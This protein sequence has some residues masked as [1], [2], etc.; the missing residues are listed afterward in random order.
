MT[1]DNEITAA[2]AYAEALA[3]EFLA[4]ID[5]YLDGLD[6]G[7]SVADAEDARAF[8]ALM[9][10]K[11]PPDWYTVPGGQPEFESPW[12]IAL[13]E[14]YIDEPKG[15]WRGVSKALEEMRATS[16]R[17]MRPQRLGVM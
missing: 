11:Y 14:G 2:V 8:V 17:G 6:Y 9:L 1:K 3:E 4:G 13:R 12:V 16:P 10:K 15:A 7:T 5:E